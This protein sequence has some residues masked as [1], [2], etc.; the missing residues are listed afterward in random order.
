M[1]RS[2]NPRASR[3]S[4]DHTSSQTYTRPNRPRNYELGS[5]SKSYFGSSSNTNNASTS[6]NTH[7]ATGSNGI[8][9]RTQTK[10]RSHSGNENK[11]L[12][13]KFELL[14]RERRGDALSSY[15]TTDD[16]SALEAD[17]ELPGDS[18]TGEE[19]TES[20]SRVEEFEEWKRSMR[21]GAAADASQKDSVHNI[22]SMLNDDSTQQPVLS[23]NIDSI[24]DDNLISN[25]FSGVP[26]GSFAHKAS[27]FSSFFKTEVDQKQPMYGGSEQSS[28]FAGAMPAPS[29]PLNEGNPNDFNRILAMLNNVNVQG[30]NQQ[31]QPQPQ[32]NLSAPENQNQ[33][34]EAP[35]SNNDD[36]FF[37]SLL[38]K[39]GG[40]ETSNEVN[41]N[42]ANGNQNSDGSK[43]PSPV[44]EKV[45]AGSITKVELNP[46]SP[47]IHPGQMPEMPFPPPQEWLQAQANGQI[48]KFPPGVMPPMMGNLPPGMI[49]FP[50]PGMHNIP[51]NM[52][53]PNMNGSNIPPGMG[54]NGMP[55]PPGMNHLPPHM[56]MPMHPGM[57]PF[58][59]G[60]PVPMG[61]IQ[62][63]EEMNGQFGP[64]GGQPSMHGM[65]MGPFPGPPGPPGLMNGRGI[66][67]GFPPNMSPMGVQPGLVEGRG[68]LSENK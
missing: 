23:T 12:L 18:I 64:R 51:P 62:N 2:D 28:R 43:N 26:V 21:R 31:P 10:N 53:P 11:D 39:S 57:P 1:N 49:P 55:I 56:M 48:P 44:T 24:F 50:P 8:T 25:K 32:P 41:R 3:G 9:S 45:R 68:Q 27:R 66:P 7:N 20:N 14:G 4:V 65:P 30:G 38:N 58:P 37:M 67:P 42:G 16:N 6:S 40:T 54:P 19:M 34:R 46:L 59:P 36:A 13:D 61:F 15:K 52:I 33:N 35:A 63:M 22:P 29:E 60:A 5:T 47:S 17:W